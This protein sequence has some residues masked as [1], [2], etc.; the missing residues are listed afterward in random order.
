MGPFVC[1]SMSVC[2]WLYVC[3][4]GCLSVSGICV[5]VIC[6]SVWNYVTAGMAR[7]PPCCHSYSSDLVQFLKKLGSSYIYAIDL[8]RRIFLLCSIWRLPLFICCGSKCQFEG[9][10]GPPIWTKMGRNAPK[11]RVIWLDDKYKYF[12][13]NQTLEN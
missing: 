1:L 4:R 6:V 3:V 8:F 13:C 11:T 7:Q 2:L 9:W 10:L 12:F 5:S